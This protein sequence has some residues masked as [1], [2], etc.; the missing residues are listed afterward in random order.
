MAKIC[1]SNKRE[2]NFTLFFVLLKNRLISLLA[3]DLARP[4]VQQMPVHS[5]VVLDPTVIIS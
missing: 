2:S 5:I 4:T 3:W 1:E